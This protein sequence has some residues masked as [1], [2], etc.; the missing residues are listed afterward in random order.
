MHSVKVRLTG[1]KMRWV[2]DLRWPT[3]LVKAMPKHWHWAKE[4]LKGI[5]MH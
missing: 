2:K 3:R 1:L 5:K 4:K